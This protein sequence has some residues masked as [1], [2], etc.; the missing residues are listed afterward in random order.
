MSARYV[1]AKIASLGVSRIFVLVSMSVICEQSG[2]DKP[3][4]RQLVDETGVSRTYAHDILSGK[5]QPSRPLALTIY[6]ATGWK[7]ELIADLDETEI[8]L[9]EQAEKIAGTLPWSAAA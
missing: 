2:M 1:S 9:L 6:R 8:I 3:T 5:Q 4:A 7:P